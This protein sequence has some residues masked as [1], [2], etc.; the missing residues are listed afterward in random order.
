MPAVPSHQ[1]SGFRPEYFTPRSTQDFVLPDGLTWVRSAVQTDGTVNVYA[2]LQTSSAAPPTV[3]IAPDSASRSLRISPY[4]IVNDD[5]AET[6]VVLNILGDSLDLSTFWAVLYA[7]HL[8]YAT[9]NPESFVELIPLS[10]AGLSN[11]TQ[12]YEY[13]THTGLAFA[14]LPQSVS[15]EYV[16][17]SVFDASDPEDAP[18]KDGVYRWDILFVSSAFFQ[19]AGAPP[20]FHFL[21]VPTPGPTLSP[22][23]TNVFPKTTVMTR[24]AND[25]IFTV[26]PLRPPKPKAGTIIYQRYINSLSPT[27]ASPSEKDA[28]NPKSTSYPLLTLQ[29]IDPSNPDHFDRYCAWQNSDRV[30]EG[31]KER[32]DEDHHR[33]YLRGMLKDPH[34]MPVLVSWSDPTVDKLG[35]RAP[36]EPVGYAEISYVKEDRVGIFTGGLGDWD[37]GTHLLVGN[38]DFRGRIRFTAIMTA[39]KHFC[40]LRDP[41]TDIVV[42]EPR[43]DL[44]I[45]PRLAS[46]LPQ[47]FNREFEMP[48]KRGVFF[49]LRRERFFQAA[50]MY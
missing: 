38:D 42:G 25:G 11:R 6:S 13:V 3:T 12:L 10:I 23:M 9:P 21:R 8:R 2:P 30:N 50:I 33:Q 18:E 14:P 24:R 44:G 45:I 39:L 40:F 16:P 37:Q 5:R 43:Y 35:E 27:S 15:P 22:Y 36:L 1:P 47:E 34:S 26:H 17:V 29:I 19:G 49:V 20:E 32:G 46:Y 41:R 31:W 7:I 48:H 4:G 28:A